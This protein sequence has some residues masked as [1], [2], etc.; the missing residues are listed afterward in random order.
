M[1]FNRFLSVRSLKKI[2]V[3]GHIN[4]LTRLLTYNY[5]NFLNFLV[6]ISGSGKFAV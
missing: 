4:A 2:F 6:K 3:A 1:I 5:F